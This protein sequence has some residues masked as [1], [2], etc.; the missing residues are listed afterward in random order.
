MWGGVPPEVVPE[1]CPKGIP[2]SLWAVL[3]LDAFFKAD[4]YAI[5]LA[6]G[7]VLRYT[8]ADIALTYAGSTYAATGVLV[9]RSLIAWRIGLEVDD[10]TL[11]LI[12]DADAEIDGVPFREALRR[13][14]LDAARVDV[15]RVFM[16]TFGDTSPGGI[17][18]FS[19][20]VA[21]CDATDKIEV[22]VA[23]DLELL[24]TKIPK[25]LYQP[26]CGWTLYD[27]NCG[28]S[29][30]AF[31]VYST[32]GSG[33]TTLRIP[34]S[35]SGTYGDGWFDLGVIRFLDGTCAGTSRSVKAWA[36]GEISLY[37]ALPAIPASGDQ[38]ELVPGCDKTR[39]M[40]LY[41]FGRGDL[42]FRGFPFIP[43]ATTAV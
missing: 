15:Y 18:L 14:A 37:L 2:C 21:D 35:V 30:S 20:R 13:G 24:D 1:V 34:V 9:E 17:L 10:L 26:G 12:P 25:N 43:D 29:R 11:T 16:E 31:T 32:V 19:G 7:T 8:S 42:I 23:S 6:S 27:A 41:K 36:S 3:L 22:A 28:V 5:T 39:T 4:L 33:A 40:C 38:V